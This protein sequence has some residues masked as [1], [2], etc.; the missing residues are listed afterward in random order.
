[1]LDW[2]QKYGALL[3]ILVLFFGRP[4]TGFADNGPPPE[5]GTEFQTELPQPPAFPLNFK[6]INADNETSKTDKEKDR[7]RFDPANPQVGERIEQDS[8]WSTDYILDLSDWESDESESDWNFD[9]E[10][11]A[12]VILGTLGTVFVLL[13][14]V[15]FSRIKIRRKRKEALNDTESIIDHLEAVTQNQP[16]E[17]LA[18]SGDFDIAVHALLLDVLRVIFKADPEM[19]RPS[20]TAR[21]IRASFE[22]PEIAKDLGPLIQ[23]VEWSRFANRPATEEDYLNLSPRCARLTAIF[24]ERIWRRDGNVGERL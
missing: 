19:D 10:M 17:K 1:M 11:I 5:F 6:N 18:I 24:E 20:I 23:V 12:I 14:V 22:E 7:E 16:H 21:E 13:L 9:G 8:N 3:I 4:Q 15:F 2:T